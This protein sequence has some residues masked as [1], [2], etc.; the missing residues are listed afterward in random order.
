MVGTFNTADNHPLVESINQRITPDSFWRS[1]ENRFVSVK[2][3]SP[4]ADVVVIAMTRNQWNELFA[5]RPNRD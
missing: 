3:L 2:S 5:G 1:E 4:D